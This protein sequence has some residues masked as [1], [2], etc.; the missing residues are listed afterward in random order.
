VLYITAMWAA[1]IMQGLMWRAVDSDG[2]LTYSFIETVEALRPY[3]L[4]RLAG[5]ATYFA[6][7]ALMV[8]NLWRTVRGARAADVVPAAQAA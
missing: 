1:G 8:Y 5:G 4:V 2:N 3:Y 7:M 6:G